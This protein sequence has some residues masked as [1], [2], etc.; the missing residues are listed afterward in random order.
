MDD[1]PQPGMV[2][3]IFTIARASRA[4]MDALA[5]LRGFPAD[6]HRFCALAAMD[7]FRSLRA[8][9]LPARF[10]VGENHCFC[11]VGALIVDTATSQFTNADPV[12][13]VWIASSIDPDMLA[14]PGVWRVTATFDTEHDILAAEFWSSWPED[15]RPHALPPR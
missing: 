2:A 14:D 7:L 11:L 15:E 4:R 10:A 1:V 12:E 8:D 5:R 3:R 9:G 6:L 13:G